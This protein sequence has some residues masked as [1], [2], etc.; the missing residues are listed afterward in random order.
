MSRFSQPICNENSTDRFRAALAKYRA[1]Q[2]KK[3]Q[4]EAQAE[5]RELQA[6][7]RRCGA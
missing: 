1:E 2:A 5:F 3:E 7:E 6:M 4:K